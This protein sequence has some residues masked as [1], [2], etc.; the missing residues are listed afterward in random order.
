MLMRIANCD[1]QW[2]EHTVDAG[3]KRIVGRLLVRDPRKRAQVKHLWDDEW[4]LG[5]GA[6]NPPPPATPPMPALEYSE[7]ECAFDEDDFGDDG[8][9]VDGDR[10]ASVASEELQ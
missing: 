3:L 5:E 8:L 7:D 10:I 2:P 1:Y 6:P 9:I 4:M